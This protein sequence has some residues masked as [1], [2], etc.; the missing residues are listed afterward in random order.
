MHDVDVGKR[1]P[2]LSNGMLF[3][4]EM[5]RNYVMDSSDP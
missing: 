2:A 5:E 4:S 1:L 3:A